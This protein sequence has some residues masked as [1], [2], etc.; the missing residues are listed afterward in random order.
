MPIC[1]TITRDPLY[2]IEQANKLARCLV[3]NRDVEGEL[4]ANVL[5]EACEQGFTALLD[6][7][8]ASGEVFRGEEMELRWRPH[9][10]ADER[11][12][13]FDLV[14]QPIIGDSGAVERIL[15]L[16]TDATEKV[17]RRS[18]IERYAS[19]RQALL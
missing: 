3:G 10:Q 9:A 15:H 5:R 2:R 12:A 13:Y 18:L 17:E 7:V 19:E 11:T 16:G 1:L 4:I 6:N 14:Y 8:Y